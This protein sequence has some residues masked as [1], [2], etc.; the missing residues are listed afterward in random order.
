MSAI[1]SPTPFA[2]A[3][4]D[5]LRRFT[6]ADYRKMIEAGVLGESEPA[7]LIE[8]VILRKFRPLTPRECSRNTLSASGS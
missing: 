8:G 3:D 5:R 6:V 1:S 4:Y 7:E 2:P